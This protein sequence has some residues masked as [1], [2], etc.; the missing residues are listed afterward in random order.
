[1]LYFGFFSE[2]KTG[3][4]PSE[5]SQLSIHLSLLDLPPHPQNDAKLLDEG[6]IKLIWLWAFFFP[7]IDHERRPIC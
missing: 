1:M 5:S 3:L 7:A 6:Y 2:P 4:Q